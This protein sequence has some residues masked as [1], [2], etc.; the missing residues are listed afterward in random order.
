MRKSV[1][2]SKS[3]REPGASATLDAALKS[4]S[5]NEKDLLAAIALS[6]V[7]FCFCLVHLPLESYQTFVRQLSAAADPRTSYSR[8]AGCGAKR[9]GN[10]S[11]SVLCPPPRTRRTCRPCFTLELKALREKHDLKQNMTLKYSAPY[12]LT[13]IGSLFHFGRFGLLYS[14]SVSIPTLIGPSQWCACSAFRSLA[15]LPSQVCCFTGS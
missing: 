8:S 12:Q 7:F 15:D 4:R 1:T 10:P 13:A 6:S 11:R 14:Q 3:G 5:S 9:A 2:A